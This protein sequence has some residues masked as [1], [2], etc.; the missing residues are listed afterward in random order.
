MA[1][2]LAWGIRYALFAYGNAGDLTFMLIIGYYFT[3][4]LL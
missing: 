4:H 2:M 1:G 3:W